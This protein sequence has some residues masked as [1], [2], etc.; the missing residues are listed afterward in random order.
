MQGYLHHR[1]WGQLIMGCLESHRRSRSV[2]KV[3]SLSSLPS[4]F[5]SRT[6]ALGFAGAEQASLSYEFACVP[7]P[8]PPQSTKGTWL[9]PL[10]LKHLQSPQ[11]SSCVHTHVQQLCLHHTF[12]HAALHSL[13]KQKQAPPR[14]CNNP[15]I[16]TCGHY[17]PLL[18]FKINFTNYLV[19]GNP[20]KATRVASSCPVQKTLSGD[21][22]LC[23]SA[24]QRLGTQVWAAAPWP[25]W[26]G[27]FSVVAPWW[28]GMAGAGGTGGCETW[29]AVQ[30]RCSQRLLL[31]P[32]YRVL[33][34]GPWRFCSPLY[35]RGS[36]LSYFQC[37]PSP[38]ERKRHGHSVPAL[39]GSIKVFQFPEIW[40][41]VFHSFQ[42]LS[43]FWLPEQNTMD[44]GMGGCVESEQQKC[45][46]AVVEAGSPRSLHRQSWCQMK[47]SWFMLPF[48]WL[49]SNSAE[50]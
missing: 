28:V 25:A 9:F 12:T 14:F 26:E 43:P 11:S 17:L 6:W 16:D 15:A 36:I 31:A 35:V 21:A 45:T 4:C 47:A 19:E 7:P 22:R 44:R 8:H 29:L 18:L 39:G 20:N 42:C 34:G 23:F 13:H 33:K 46:L 1:Q 32:P 48:S 3:A 50:M 5:H 40:K 41:I 10:W 38:R 27:L 30:H 37:L 2:V 49:I 24:L